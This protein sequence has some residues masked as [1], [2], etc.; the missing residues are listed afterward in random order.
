MTTL[1]KPESGQ[2][3][4]ETA[5][6]AREFAGLGS[7]SEFLITEISSAAHLL[8]FDPSEPLG[9]CDGCEGCSGCSI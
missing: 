1:L 4:Q 5:M 2:C 7:P 9:F 3:Q 8:A 6:E